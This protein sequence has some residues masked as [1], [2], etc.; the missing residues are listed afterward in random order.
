MNIDHFKA[1]LIA[2]KKQTIEAVESAKEDTKAVTLDQTSVGRLSRMDAMQQ[3]AM[4][5]ATQER[6]QHLLL[7]IEQGFKRIENGHFGYCTQCGQEIAPKR[8]EFNP[9]V[10]TCIDC[11]N[12]KD[13]NS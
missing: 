9:V 2:L 4:A 5:L 10:L 6:R 3:Q 11:A 1:C 7:A 12:Q 13:T 8:L